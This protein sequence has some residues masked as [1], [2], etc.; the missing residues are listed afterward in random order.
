MQFLNPNKA[1]DMAQILK[2]MQTKYVPANG[3]GNADTDPQLV[4]RVIFDGDQLTEERARNCQWANTLAEGEID[5]LDGI[6]PAFADWHLK[7]IL[8]GVGSGIQLHYLIIIII[9]IIS[10]SSSSS[11]SRQKA[12]VNHKR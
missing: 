12:S 2:E 5:R 10:S 4:Q 6:T 11:S 1:S 8:L 7:K 3:T 9:I